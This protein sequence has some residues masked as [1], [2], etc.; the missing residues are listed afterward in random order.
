MKIVLKL[1]KKIIII[2]IILGILTTF[3]DYNRIKNNQKP[4]FN[5][6]NYN[7]KTHIESY[8][9]I[10]YQAKRKIKTSP[11]EEIKD[12][13]NIKFYILTYELK[14]PNL[15]Q[16]DNYS[17]TINTKELTN[18]LEESKLYYADK[19]IKIY[20]YCLEKI[21]IIKNNKSEELNKYMK[22]NEQAIDEILNNLDFA[23]LYPDSTTFMYL[24][25]NN[26]ITNN[27]LTIYQCNK[28]NI[29][30]IYIGPNNMEFRGDFCT[31]KDDDYKFISEILDESPKKL[32]TD[33]KEV[34]YEDLEYTYE[35]EYPRSNY[36]FITTPA[37]RGT[38]ETKL[39]LKDVLVNN[40]LTIN[41]LEEKGLKFTKTA[42]N[43]Q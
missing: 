13:S 5:T 37:V 25:A 3:I 41:D 1:I 16:N 30:D 20:T 27:G 26:N 21:E 40:L 6:S 36:I 18:C 31:Y 12:S 8:R 4:I 42:K 39:P 23:G 14:I 2:I 10:L 24:N 7:K 19:N 38:V 43:I 11:E 9:G 32:E 28:E 33:Q 17:F 15:K 22:N 34:F 35:F 29:N